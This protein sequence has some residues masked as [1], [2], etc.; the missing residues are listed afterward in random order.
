MTKYAKPDHKTVIA[1]QELKSS[2]LHVCLKAVHCQQIEEHMII[3]IGCY[4]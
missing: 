3:P 2:T 4:Y 1:K